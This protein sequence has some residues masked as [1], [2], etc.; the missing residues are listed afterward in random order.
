MGLQIPIPMQPQKRTT[1]REV[2]TR[3]GQLPIRRVWKLATR[4]NQTRTEKPKPRELHQRQ[5]VKCHRTK[6]HNKGRAFYFD[7]CRVLNLICEACQS[8]GCPCPPS[9]LHTHSQDERT[10]GPF[11]QANPRQTHSKLRHKVGNFFWA[12]LAGFPRGRKRARRKRA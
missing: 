4:A 7:K 5:Y 1:T 6:D 12:W 8:K 10:C 11:S 3:C 9:L 2:L